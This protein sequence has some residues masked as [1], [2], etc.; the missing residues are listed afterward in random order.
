VK[1]VKLDNFYKV[2]LTIV[3][4]LLIIIIGVLSD[5]MVK[6][7]PATTTT[8]LVTTQ[9]TTTTPV[10]T[11]I[12]NV[13][14]TT[15]V[16]TTTPTTTTPFDCSNAGFK[17]IEGSYSKSSAQLTVTLKNTEAVDL[18]MEYI[19]FT[20][21]SGAV[22]RNRISGLLEG[23]VLEGYMTRSF[24]ISQVED[25]FRTGKITT[26]CPDVTVEFTYSDVT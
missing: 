3:I 7:E 2:G 17:F 23:R 11:T 12:A 10:T 16:T 24:L 20:Y 26:N 13:T 9:P 6:V 5:Y 15:T 8:T 21:P 1:R 25:R 19:F 14:P 18:N 4:I 22:V